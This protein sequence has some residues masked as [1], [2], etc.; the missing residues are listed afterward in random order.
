MISKEKKEK[1]IALLA[2]ELSE[3][4]NF[5]LE[6]ALAIVQKSAVCKMLEEDDDAVWQMHQPLD[7]TVENIFREYKGEPVCV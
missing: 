5:S 4:Y 1:Y 6:K 3:Y 7:D 2:N